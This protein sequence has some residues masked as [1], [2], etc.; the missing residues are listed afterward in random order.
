MM[1]AV[2]CR[3]KVRIGFVCCMASRQNSQQ[4]RWGEVGSVLNFDLQ[5]THWRGSKT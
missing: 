2:S 1:R 5:T 4:V 3:S